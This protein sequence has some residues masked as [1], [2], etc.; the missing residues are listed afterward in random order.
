MQMLNVPTLDFVIDRV[1]HAFVLRDLK[2]FLVKEL[3]AS[4]ESTVYV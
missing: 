1:G 2:E 3:L 4:V